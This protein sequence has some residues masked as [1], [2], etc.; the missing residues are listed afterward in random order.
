M[1]DPAPSN[2]RLLLE[3][4]DAR[5]ERIRHEQALAAA[6][7]HGRRRHRGVCPAGSRVTPR[8]DCAA[9]CPA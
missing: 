2:T 7:P 6:P 8:P 3:L 5:A 1:T 4:D 9:E